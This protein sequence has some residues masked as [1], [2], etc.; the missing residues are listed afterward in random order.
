MV[1]RL[2]CAAALVLSPTTSQA[3]APRRRAEWR[4]L[5]DVPLPGPPARFDY[6]SFDPA[7]GR[8]WIAHMRAAEVLA[9]DVRTWRVVTRVT[10][11]P[12]VTGVL[13]VSALHRVFAALSES[14]QVAVLDARTGRVLRRLPGGRFPDGLAYAPAVHKVFVSDEHGGQE[15]V[16][17]AVSSTALPP[18][19]VGGEVGNTQYDSGSGRIWVAVQTRNQLA[20]IDPTTDSVVAWVAVP[21]VEQPHGLLIDATHHLAYVAGEGNGRVGVLDLRTQQ[22]VGTYPGA[23]EPDVLAIDPERHLLFVAAES[24]VVAAF[25]IRG[26]SLLALPSYRAPHAHSVAVDAGTHLIYLPLEDIGGRPVLRILRL[27]EP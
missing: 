25:D 26:D 16:I 11:M 3:Q 7:T 8:L 12:G 23:D 19:P 5:A 14:H 22:V 24:G 15:L 4:V 2:L 18:I 17:D 10:E 20:V 13:V 6:Q 9:F 21:G 1:T 27:E